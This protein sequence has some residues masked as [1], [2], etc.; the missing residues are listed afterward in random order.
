[1][2]SRKLVE[3]VTARVF[4]H[5]PG[6]G[7][8]VTVFA[9]QLPLSSTSQA[10][11]AKECEWE[12]V[13]VA[14]NANTNSSAA[15]T[16][17]RTVTLP[18]MAFYMP[19]GEE[20][21]F[22]AH[23]ALGGASAA[24]SFQKDASTST[25]T[26]TEC[27]FRVRMTGDTQVV[28]LPQNNTN[29]NT[30]T[31]NKDDDGGIMACLHMQANFE[32]APVSHAPSLQ[33]L[34]RER[35]GITSSD[36]LMPRRP[37]TFVN[38]SIARPKTLVRLNSVQ[39]LENAKPPRA[40]EVAAVSDHNDDDNDDDEQTPTTTTRR[41]RRPRTSFASACGAIDDSTG[42]YLYAAKDDEEG[43]G[44]W[45]CRQFPRAS[46][47]PEDPATGIAAAALAASLFHNSV[48]LPVYKFY[49]GTTMGR[50]SLIQVLDLKMDGTKISFG[51]KGRVEIDARETIEVD[52][53]E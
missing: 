50:P 16:T 51:L 45:E 8:P 41:P 53:E 4:C 40:V 38:S 5:G 21:S 36:V 7:N 10:R 28:E 11:L 44:A 39:A 26:S 2:A 42:I 6:G 37:P 47:Y 1:M 15:G 33:R 30:N 20:V 49:Q 13:M 46:G 35:L 31:N 43:G 9:S 3:R 12:S 48:Y 23:A 22:C 14:T 34:L 27:S 25:S 52:D 17:T 24:L 32:E 18:E 29:T 19:S